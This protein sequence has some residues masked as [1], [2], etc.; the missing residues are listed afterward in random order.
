MTAQ[1]FADAFN[2]LLYAV[3]QDEEFVA[4]KAEAKAW[5]ENPAN[6]R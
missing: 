5:R 6:P 1:S 4:F 2:R 3:L